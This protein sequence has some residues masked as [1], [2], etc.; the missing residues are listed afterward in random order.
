MI[1]ANTSVSNII[2]YPPGL[3][4]ISSSPIGVMYSSDFVSG[5][6]QEV[7]AIYRATCCAPRVVINAVDAYGNTNS[8]TIDISGEYF[9][10][11]RHGTA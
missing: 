5:T 11:K 4:R 3:L 7:M 10:S 8:Y 6:R 1:E 9:M 2:F